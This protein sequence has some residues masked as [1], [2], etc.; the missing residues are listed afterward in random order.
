MTDSSELNRP[1]RRDRRASALIGVLTALLGFAI[2]VQL[3]SASTEDALAGARQDDLVRI[4]DDQNSRATRLRARIAE[5]EALLQRLTAAGGDRAAAE[6]EARRQADALAVLTGTVAVT[7]PGVEVTITDP[8]R[9]LHAEDLLDVIEELR[10]A[11]AEAVQFGGVRVTTSSYFAESGDAVALDGVVLSRPYTVLA[12]GD[13]STLDTAL[14]IP[15][16]VAAVAR[17]AG[18]DATVRQRSRVDITAV[19][20]LHEYRY[21]VPVSR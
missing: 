9:Q 12:I 10:G 20:T 17:T 21:A 8:E 11:G 18:G 4:L 14:N 15:G 3:R 2:A 5:E 19:G 16:G 1:A 13:P 6:E 7:G